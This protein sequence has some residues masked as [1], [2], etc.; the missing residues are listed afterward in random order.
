MILFR[1]ILDTGH[2]RHNINALHSWNKADAIFAN[3]TVALS[4]EKNTSVQ[5]FCDMF[6]YQQG[7]KD[8]NVFQDATLCYF[9]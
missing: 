6:R 5:K 7:Q 9:G 1:V 3:G 2:W 8:N 4:T